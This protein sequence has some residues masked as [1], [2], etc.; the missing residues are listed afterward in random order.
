MGESNSAWGEVAEHDDELAEV[1]DGFDRLPSAGVNDVLDAFCASKRIDIPSLVRIGTK[2]AGYGVLAFALPGGI[3]YRNMEQGTRWAATGSEFT[4]LKIVR[5]GVEQAETVI[6][7]E[8]ETDGARLTMLYPDCDVA[9]LPAGAKRFTQGFADQL[10]PYQRVLASYDPDDAGN[11]G[12]AKLKGAIDKAS[13]FNAPGGGDWCAYEGD[14]PE[15]PAGAVVLPVL[16]SARDLLDL[17][18]PDTASWFE[19]ALLPIGGQLVIHGW[20]KS[21]KSYVGLDMLAAVA[22]AQD[23][24]GFEPT[25]EA[26]KVAVVQ[27]EVPPIY[28]R[29]RVKALGLTA[30]EPELFLD[31][32]LSLSPLTLPQLKAGVAAQEEFVRRTLVEAGVQVALFDPL[33]RMMRV[34]QSLNDEDSVR[35]PLSFFESLQREGIA[36]VFCHHDT[37]SSA[38]SNTSDSSDMTGSGAFAGDA[39]TVVGISRPK[40]EDEKSPLRNLH[41]LTRNAASPDP[42][43]LQMHDDEHIIYS[44]DAHVSGDDDPTEATI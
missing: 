4:T 29:Q 2:L 21:F 42:R 44:L 20:V 18:L 33:R 16:V 11:E 1:W 14:A 28:Y 24:C 41:F 19:N 31:N 7:A 27:F 10:L 36:V 32:F 37:K 38:K 9:I 5:S 3:K 25:E 34:G 23:W 13:R 35:A 22:Q 8:G 40:G 43:G 15:L 6:V 26:A 17:E 30:R 39:D 12:W